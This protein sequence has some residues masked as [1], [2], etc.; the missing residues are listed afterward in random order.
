MSVAEVAEMLKLNQQPI[1]TWIDGGKLPTGL[2]RRVRIRRVDVDLF[3]KADYG[4]GRLPA[5]PAQTNTSQPL[6][7]GE[8]IRMPV[9]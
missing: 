8:H 5:A 2:S 7:L 4:A 1:R 3:W 6:R 9:R